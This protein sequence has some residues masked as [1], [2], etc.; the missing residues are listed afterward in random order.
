MKGEIPIGVLFVVDEHLLVVKSLLFLLL[1]LFRLLLP[2][3][4]F[5]FHALLQSRIIEILQ[6][7]LIALTLDAIINL[8]IFVESFLL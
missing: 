5:P 2:L 4:L 6:F 3:V 7:L 1:T 8:V